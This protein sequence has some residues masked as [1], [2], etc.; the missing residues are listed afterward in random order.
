[1]LHALRLLGGVA[2]SGQLGLSI[3]FSLVGQDQLFLL[4]HHL[5]KI[6]FQ[7]LLPQSFRFDIFEKLLNGAYV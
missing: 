2:S 4:A 5:L 1:V 7:A 3:R 6:P